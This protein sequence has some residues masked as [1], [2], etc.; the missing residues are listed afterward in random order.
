MKFPK[1]LIDV[2][3]NIN[4]FNSKSV[5]KSGKGR[6]KS[7]NQKVLL[8]LISQYKITFRTLDQSAKSKQLRIN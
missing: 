7:M 2:K 3:I 4:D 8:D 1:T 5:E 6:L